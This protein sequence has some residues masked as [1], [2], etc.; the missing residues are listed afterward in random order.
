MASRNENWQHVR[1][2]GWADEVD[3]EW[4]SSGELTSPVYNESGN[5]YR[6]ADGVW[7]EDINVQRGQSQQRLDLDSGFMRTIVSL[8]PQNNQFQFTDEL[9]SRK[10]H[11]SR[12]IWHPLTEDWCHG[13]GPGQA[14]DAFTSA[15]DPS[16]AFILA[17]LHE[18]N[19]CLL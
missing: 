18:C 3:E 17:C 10:V 1:T 8:D 11:V 15:L 12:F 5:Q 9:Q 19:E 2:R 6:S 13:W 4:R 7:H 16:C 14:L